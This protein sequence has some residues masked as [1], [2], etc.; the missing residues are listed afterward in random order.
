MLRVGFHSR[1]VRDSDSVDRKTDF[2]GTDSERL[3]L[4]S[5]RSFSIWEK[6]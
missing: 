2:R 6:N 4:V 5:R 3:N 1:Y